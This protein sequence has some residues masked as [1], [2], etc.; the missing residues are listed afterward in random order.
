MSKTAPFSVNSSNKILY[1]DHVIRAGGEI[2]AEGGA[3]RGECRIPE[4]GGRPGDDRG[5]RRW[6][7]GQDL[8]IGNHQDGGDGNQDLHLV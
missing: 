6:R 5:L 4:Q 2:S 1:L 8:T 3:A 7:I